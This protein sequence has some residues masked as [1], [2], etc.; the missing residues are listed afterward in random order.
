MVALAAF[1]STAAVLMTCCTRRVRWQERMPAKASTPP[2]ASPCCH[3]AANQ[4]GLRAC[5]QETNAA[6]ALTMDSTPGSQA[7][8]PTKKAHL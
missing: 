8:I 6:A 5:R 3:D 2:M 1:I 4:E 7:Q